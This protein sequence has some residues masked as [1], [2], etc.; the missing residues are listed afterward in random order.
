MVS[1]LLPVRLLLGLFAV[2]F[3]YYFGRT[4]IAKW[5]GLIPTG[6]LV[7]WSLRLVLT[8]FGILWT[9]RDWLAVLL[10]ALAGLSA[11]LGIYAQSRPTDHGPS[12]RLFPGG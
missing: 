2:F 8:I 4:L 10:L 7:H 12:T 6:R 9:G 1:P 5:E 3:A 11:G